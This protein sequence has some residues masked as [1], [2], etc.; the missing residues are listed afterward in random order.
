MGTKM[1]SQYRVWKCWIFIRSAPLAAGAKACAWG[2]ANQGCLC[3]DSDVGANDTQTK[4]P[5]A[6]C[7]F[8][9][10]GVSA[11][12][13]R[14][15]WGHS[16]GVLISCLAWS[17]FRPSYDSEVTHYLFKKLVCLTQPESFCCLLW[18]TL[19]DMIVVI[20]IDS[21]VFSF[22]NI[23]HIHYTLM[24]MQISKLPICSRYLL[25]HLTNHP[26][27]LVA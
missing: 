6:L 1:T 18:R 7:H 19:A 8:C 17:F 27:I 21:A 5:G 16:V 10:D 13:P 3:Q 11:F 22:F 20:T 2:S 24:D 23:Y 14:M 9:G 15:V 12:L 26:Q 25:M 4:G